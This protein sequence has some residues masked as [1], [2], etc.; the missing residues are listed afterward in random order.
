MM[1][2]LVDMLPWTSGPMASRAGD[3]HEISK[4]L[5]LDAIDTSIDFL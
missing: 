2:Q 5:D 3:W 4:W 1:K